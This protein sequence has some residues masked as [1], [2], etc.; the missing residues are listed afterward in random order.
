MVTG[1]LREDEIEKLGL[2][3][4]ANYIGETVDLS[5]VNSSSVNRGRDSKSLQL[6]CSKLACH[7][8]A[9]Q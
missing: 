2:F 3:A 9:C 6:N 8:S 4:A 1:S 7:W 5:S